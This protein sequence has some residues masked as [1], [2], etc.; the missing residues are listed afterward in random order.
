MMGN[1]TRKVEQELQWQRQLVV[2]GNNC[3]AECKEKDCETGILECTLGWIRNK[4]NE[5]GHDSENKGF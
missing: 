5:S 2:G 1:V 4:D 3:W